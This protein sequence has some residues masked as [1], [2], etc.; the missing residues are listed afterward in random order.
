MTPAIRGVPCGAS[1]SRPVADGRDR[2]APSPVSAY[3]RAFDRQ[4]RCQTP[5]PG[6][7]AFEVRVAGEA[8]A[9]L[10]AAY[11][12]AAWEAAVEELATAEKVPY[13]PRRG[14]PTGRGSLLFPT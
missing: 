8:A 7:D 1:S 10:S 4:W 3:S 12:S 14:D 6:S 9:Y 2:G 13:F 11:L 5:I